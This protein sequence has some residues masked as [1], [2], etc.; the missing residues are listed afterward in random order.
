[1][2]PGVG[3]GGHALHGGYGPISRHWGLI[4]DRITAIQVVLADGSCVIA[5]EKEHSDLYWALRGAG[6]SFGVAVVSISTK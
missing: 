6:S 3:L 4:L 5:S 1:M 2:C